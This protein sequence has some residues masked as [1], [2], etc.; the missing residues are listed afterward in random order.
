MFACPLEAKKSKVVNECET[1]LLVQHRNCDRRYA[2]S[3]AGSCGS[4]RNGRDKTEDT[5]MRILEAKVR[6]QT[7]T[8][9]ECLR[10]L[11]AYRLIFQFVL[12]KIS[13]HIRVIPLVIAYIY[14]VRFFPPPLLLALASLPK[15]YH[16]PSSCQNNPISLP[17]TVK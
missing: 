2:Q 10:C 11:R 4:Q 14:T 7:A 3:K 1:R 9:K 16:T 6:L 17:S 13:H 8:V 12:W 15:V 5:T